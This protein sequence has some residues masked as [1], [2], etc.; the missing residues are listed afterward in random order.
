MF[1]SYRSHTFDECFQ[2]GYAL[3]GNHVFIRRGSCPND[4]PSGGGGG[5]GGWFT[6]D[7]SV[8]I[9]LNDDLVTSLTTKFDTRGHGGVL[10][11]NGFSNVINK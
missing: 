4:S 11:A 1:F 9:Y 3:N 7:K 6:S 5:G 2:H 10:V 8:N